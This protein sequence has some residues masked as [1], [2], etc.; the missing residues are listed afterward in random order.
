MSD[1]KHG[2][3]SGLIGTV[4]KVWGPG[5]LQ[6]AKMRGPSPDR[7]AFEPHF[8]GAKDSQVARALLSGRV[9]VAGLGQPVDPAG[10]AFWSVVPV[11]NEMFVRLHAF[12]W[13]PALLAPGGGQNDD[14]SSDLPDSAQRQALA[15]T[16]FDRWI[17]HYERWSPDVWA[18]LVTAERLTQILCHQSVLLGQ[19]ALTERSRILNSLARQTRFLAQNAHK[20]NAGTDQLITAI[21]LSI[22]AL[23]IPGCAGALENGQE[24][25]RRE[26]RL[27]MR[28]DGGHISR[29]PSTQLELALRLHMLRETYSGLGRN[30]PG[31]VRLGAERMGVM[32]RFFRLGDGRL[33]VFNGGYEDDPNCVEEVLGRI[34]ADSPVTSVARYSHYQ[35]V[36][37]ARTT[38]IA[39]VG[40]RREP[41]SRRAFDGASAF[42]F[43]VGRARL[44][45]NC[46]NGEAEGT[47]WFDALRQAAA[48]STLSFEADAA[49]E[50]SLFAPKTEHTRT[51]DIAGSLIEIFRPFSAR[52]T[53][54]DTGPD[55]A[56]VA[57]AHA[58]GDPGHFR[59]LY[60]AAGGDDIR[61]EDRISRLPEAFQP[62]W[63]L[64]FHLHPGV[65]ASLARDN[66]SVLIV[67]RSGEGWR[68][69]TDWPMLSL[70][71]S[72]YFGGG[73][74]PVQTQQIVLAPAPVSE[75]MQSDPADPAEG[76]PTVL[77][78]EKPSDIMI[79]WAFRR[80]DHGRG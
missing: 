66:R 1:K 31:F 43:S 14:P 39:D 67:L 12:S 65:K 4:Q 49:P 72:V 52:L 25:V 61:G 47:T 38:L 46:G 8:L 23:C 7:I 44:V 33:A 48:H 6:Q 34:D 29:N 50:R 24:L 13:L 28:S 2:A 57:R 77:D 75:K 63:R 36:E 35:R 3:G 68:F 53:G 56:A 41:F 26:L 80:L 32:V 69:R 37:A 74:G 51:E 5:P 42:E 11:R 40:D 22:A 60:V 20:A 9:E 17:D 78:T 30:V 71:P 76:K 15:R 64:R 59:A 62:H 45:V 18:P 19:R 79:R 27:Q 21:G 58:S 10:E 54:A 55:P 73:S 16:L 70:V